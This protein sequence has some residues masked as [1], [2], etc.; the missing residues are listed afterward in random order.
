M[1][2]PE[3][4]ICIFTYNYEN[5]LSQAIE[6]VLSQE[7]NFIFEI[8]IGDDASTDRTTDIIIDY[9][10]NYPAIIRY[11]PNK[12]N[13]GGTKN[14]I[15]TINE[16]KGK[17]IALLDGDDYFSDKKKLQNQFD[18]LENNNKYVLCFHSVEEKYDDAPELNKF[19]EFQ[20]EAYKLS[21]FI[22]NG[23]FVRTSSTFF[24]NH[25]TPTAFPDWVFDFPY[26]F[27]TILHVFLCIHGD[28]LNIKEYK[29][30]WRKHKKGMSYSLMEDMLKNT[31]KKIELAI[32]LN[33]FTNFEFQRETNEFISGE[34][35]LLFFYLLRNFLFWKFPTVFI[36]CIIKLNY[37]LFFKLLKGKRHGIKN[38]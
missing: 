7:C 4:S 11:L 32:K 27:D 9:M 34:K 38:A 25:I 20:K 29:S 12:V 1:I 33:E 3:V 35:T 28:A 36:G 19:I 30:V 22:T 18:A 31:N 17:Y 37:S 16:C 26:R 5:Y 6:S 8:I 23:W 13:I 21:D 14:W 2:K 24:R 15:R 10:N